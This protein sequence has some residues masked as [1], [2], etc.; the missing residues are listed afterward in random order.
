[1]ERIG[2]MQMIDTLAPGGA[3]R[4][5]VNLANLLPRAR[6]RSYLCT[7]RDTGALAPLIEPDIGRLDLARRRTLDFAALR[8]LAAFVQ[9]QQIQ[10]LHAHG[11]SLLTA[12]L[13]TLWPPYPRLVWHDHYGNHEQ[14]ERPAWLYR[15]LARRVSGVLAVNQRLADWARDRLHVPAERISY[16]ANFVAAP[17]AASNPS[18]TAPG[19]PGKRIICVANFRPQKDHLTLLR[20]LA[21]VLNQ[22][23]QAQLLLA[24]AVV[25]PAYFAQV[26]DEIARLGLTQNVTILGEQ[27]DIHSWLRVCDIGVLSSASEGLPLSLIE[28]GQAGLAAVATRVGQCAEVLDEGEAGRLAAPAQPGELAEALLSLLGSGETRA[29]LGSRLQH[30]VAQTY[31]ATTALAAIIQ[32]YEAALRVA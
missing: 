24:G 8:R 6:F 7:T 4:V 32:R 28:Y 16:I 20:A 3:E 1:M 9:T 11:T 5:A 14:A 31:S 29:L 26:K 10:I 2:V 13:V 25:E 12:A 30:R 17:G 19:Q 18:P 22:E 15:L 21:Q 27:R 23:P